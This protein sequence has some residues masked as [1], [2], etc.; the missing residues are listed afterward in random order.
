MGYYKDYNGYKRVKGLLCTDLQLYMEEIELR[1]EFEIKYGFVPGRIVL[2]DNT[3]LCKTWER[4]PG[5]DI[6][7]YRLVQHVLKHNRGERF[8]KLRLDYR[9][10][11]LRREEE[12]REQDTLNR[13]R[14]IEKRASEAHNEARL[15]IIRDAAGSYAVAYANGMLHQR[16]TEQQ[17][18][19]S[20]AFVVG[21]E[22]AKQRIQE[23][24]HSSMTVAQVEQLYTAEFRTIMLGTLESL[25]REH[26]DFQQ[27]LGYTVEAIEDIKARG[28]SML[29][30]A[31]QIDHLRDDVERDEQRWRLSSQMASWQDEV[32]ELGSY[33]QRG[34]VKHW[35]AATPTAE[36]VQELLH[37]IHTIQVELMSTVLKYRPFFYEY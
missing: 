29:G 10:A 33:L 13:A 25:R 16:V 26:D 12:D 19:A 35:A 32:R 24:E 6:W 34:D 7:L 17:A 9:A 3:W 14:A 11:W 22:I 1:V 2:Q 31:D 20:H 28:T 23:S 37:E 18:L 36:R 21:M 8:G 5:H 15:S 4:D 30:I 27:Q